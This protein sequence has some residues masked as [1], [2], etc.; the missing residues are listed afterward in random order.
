[1]AYG[2]AGNA[3]MTPMLSASTPTQSALLQNNGMLSSGTTGA[4]DWLNK[5]GSVVR[6]NKELFHLGGSIAQSMFGPEAEL[7]DLKKQEME[8]RR[9]NANAIIPLGNLGSL[10]RG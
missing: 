7:L 5:A 8:R 3:G 1:V 4:L 6:D 2:Q 9:R 10:G